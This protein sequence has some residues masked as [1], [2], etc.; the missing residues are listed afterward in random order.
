MQNR[1]ITVIW[2]SAPLTVVK[3]LPSVVNAKELN[4][5]NLVCFYAGGQKQRAMLDIRRCSRRLIPRMQIPHL[6]YAGSALFDHPAKTSLPKRAVLQSA[7]P[8][9][10]AGESIRYSL[11]FLPVSC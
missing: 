3:S 2:S 4:D 8:S 11:S 9:I 6:Q 1:A 5:F 10:P 7:D